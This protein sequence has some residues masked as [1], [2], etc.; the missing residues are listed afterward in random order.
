MSYTEAQLRELAARG[1]DELDGASATD[2]LRWTDAHFGGV[3]GPGAG[4]PATTW[5]PP[6]CKKPCWS[7]WPPK[8]ARACR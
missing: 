3:N 5:S 6:T 8:C 4:P 7:T 2:L 1:A